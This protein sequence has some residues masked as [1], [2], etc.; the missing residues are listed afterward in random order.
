MG[1]SRNGALD[2]GAAW[3]QQAIVTCLGL[4]FGKLTLSQGFESK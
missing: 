2:V 3:K 4:G 1:S